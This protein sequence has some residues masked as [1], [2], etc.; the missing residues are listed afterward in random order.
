MVPKRGSVE[1]LF[2]LESKYP[3]FCGDWWVKGVVTGVM[4]AGPWAYLLPW[5]LGQT[6]HLSLGP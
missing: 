2:S 4:G 1:L 5:V 3:L 6:V